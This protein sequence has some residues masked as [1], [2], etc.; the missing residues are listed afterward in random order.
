VTAVVSLGSNLG[1]RL[2]ML[3]NGLEVMAQRVAVT[4]VSAVFETAPL[5]VT[6]QP[7]Y[8][9]AVA[10]I[11]SSDAEA[12]F[13]AAQQAEQSQ[14]R[15]R[16]SRWGPRT[17]DV[18]VIAVDDIVSDDVRL[19]LPHPRAHDRA[20]VLEPWLEL[21]PAAVL[22]GRGPVRDLL[23]ALAVQGIRRFAEPL[24]LP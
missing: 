3:R 5:G 19:T 4:A 21:D 17:L 15:V 8:L 24:P 12:V 11:D 7:A 14:G 20:F 9:N 18:D 2:A 6:D 1:D 23:A 22:A 16:A 10:L 13:G